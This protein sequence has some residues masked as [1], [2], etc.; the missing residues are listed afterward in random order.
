MSPIIARSKSSLWLHIAFICALFLNFSF[1]VHARTII[2]EWDNV[3]PPPTSQSAAMVSLGDP[4]IAYRLFGYFLQNAGNTGGKYESLRNYDYAMLEQWFM[5]ADDLN[6]RSDLVPFLAAFYFGVLYDEPEKMRHVARYLA[7]AGMAPYPEKWRWLA[8][9][10]YLARH[11]V[12]DLPLAL[13]YA[14]TLANHP[15]DVAIW[16]RQMPAFVQLGMDNKQ[17]SYEIMRKILITDGEKLHPNEVN[18][19]IDFICKQTLSPEE[20]ARDPICQSPQ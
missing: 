10:A 5:V 12:K 4:E 14:N 16:G 3:P 6:P 1:W 13:E 7:K 18:Y 9:A 19:M 2:Q 17:A 11:Q 15:G 8:H 20:A